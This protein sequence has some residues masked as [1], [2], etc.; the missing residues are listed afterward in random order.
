MWAPAPAG[1]RLLALHLH[2]L[3]ANTIWHM[4]SVLHL[5]LVLAEVVWVAAVQL[6]VGVKLGHSFT[7]QWLLVSGRQTWRKCLP[8]LL[9]VLEYREKGTVSIATGW[10]NSPGGT[11]TFIISLLIPES[12]LC[13][14]AVPG[15]QMLYSIPV[16]SLSCW[17]CQCS[18]RPTIWTQIITDNNSVTVC[19]LGFLLQPG[20]S[21]QREQSL[22]V[23][24]S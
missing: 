8:M 1:R 19:S 21:S 12:V 4:P 23:V 9:L 5:K 20:A 13:W 22:G 18:C 16:H 2:Q 15:D 3:C 17:Y 7:L 10:L 14:G 11:H 6:W 24:V